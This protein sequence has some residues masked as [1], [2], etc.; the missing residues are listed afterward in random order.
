MNLN[1]KCHYPITGRQIRQ[2]ELQ[3]FRAIDTKL[4]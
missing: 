4:R 3:S 1:S 2:R